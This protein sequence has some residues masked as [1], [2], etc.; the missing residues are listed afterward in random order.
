MGTTLTAGRQDARGTRTPVTVALL[1][2]GALL[3]PL[4]TLLVG[5]TDT[6]QQE[7]D[8]KYSTKSAHADTSV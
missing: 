6:N 5:D 8:N 3:R 2:F 1:R 7:Q 4:A